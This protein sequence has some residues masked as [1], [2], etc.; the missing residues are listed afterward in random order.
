MGGEAVFPAQL[1]DVKAA[2][3][4]VR[5]FAAE[6]GVDAG[7]IAV[8]GESAGGLLASLLALTGDRPD[9]RGDLGILDPPDRVDG[10]VVWYAPSD[11][12]TLAGQRPPWAR[13]DDGADS[14]E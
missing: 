1:H 6:L 13:G 12:L 5:H 10:A 4:W 11:L 3:R 14:P 8:W 9:L 2:V 7:R